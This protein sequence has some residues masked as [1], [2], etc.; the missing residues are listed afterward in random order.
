MPVF[1]AFAQAF[2]QVGTSELFSVSKRGRIMSL[3]IFVIANFIHYVIAGFLLFVI[4]AHYFPSL[5]ARS[6]HH[7]T[8]IPFV[9]A[10]LP[11][12]HLLALVME[13]LCRAGKDYIPIAPIA[14]GT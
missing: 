11:R 12:N 3:F 8:L 5:Q 6:F 9:I 4:A 14:I 10:G 13:F 2:R 1:F 7:Y